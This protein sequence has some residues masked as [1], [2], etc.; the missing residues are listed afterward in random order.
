MKLLITE[1]QYNFIKQHIINEIKTIATPA[2]DTGDKEVNFPT[3]SNLI[4]LRQEINKNVNLYGGITYFNDVKEGD[5]VYLAI[6]SK[7]GQITIK[8]PNRKFSDG[9]LGST[10]L[11]DNLMFAIKA[12]SGN[13]ILL[14]PGRGSVDGKPYTTSAASDV[15][16]KCYV[17][18]GEDIFE[19]CA[20]NV[21]E[22]DNYIAKDNTFI[23]KTDKQ[24]NRKEF[25][26]NREKERKE[27]SNKRNP[28]SMS[29]DEE[30]AY[31]DKQAALYAKYHGSELPIG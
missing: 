13:D 12:Y 19:W 20:K 8:T 10:G 26:D 16:I 14:R 23:G 21:R 30:K 25:I 29:S 6:V 11:R 27:M 31:M 3:K 4:K 1:S 15:R 2:N 24:I 28:I 7:N 18:Y 5:G 22:K 9:E 17:I